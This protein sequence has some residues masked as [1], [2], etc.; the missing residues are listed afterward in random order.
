[1]SFDRRPFPTLL[2]PSRCRR[3]RGSVA[4]RCR[5]GHL[6]IRRSTNLLPLPCQS[7]SAAASA[8]GR[9]SFRCTIGGGAWIAAILRPAGDRDSAPALRHVGY[10][11]PAHRSAALLGTIRQAVNRQPRATRPVSGAVHRPGDHRR[12]LL[13]VRAFARDGC[14]LGWLPRGNAGG[15]VSAAP[16]VI[17]RRALGL[18]FSDSG[19]GSD[20]QR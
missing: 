15:T 10:W 14:D 11:R 20:A 19:V 12:P 2:V 18:W 16:T 8:R 1:M 9:V 3:R 4:E 17:D 13:H 6:A 5:G 7:W